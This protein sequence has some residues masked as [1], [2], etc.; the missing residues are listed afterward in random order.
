MLA[1]SL[2][3]RSL[4]EGVSVQPLSNN[5]KEESHCTPSSSSFPKGSVLSSKAYHLIWT[6]L[7]V[8]LSMSHKTF[9]RRGRA[10]PLPLTMINYKPS[11]FLCPC[12]NSLSVRLSTHTVIA[13]QVHR[14]FF[15]SSLSLWSPLYLTFG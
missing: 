14:H 11:I 9:S 6:L 1:L 4:W 7:K 10:L 8:Q 2:R 12:F 5:C 15:P 13:S 3:S